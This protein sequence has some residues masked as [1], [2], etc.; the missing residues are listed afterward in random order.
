MLLNRVVQG[1]QSGAVQPI[2]STYILLQGLC[3][4]SFSHKPLLCLSADSFY[5]VS[6]RLTQRN[7]IPLVGQV[8]G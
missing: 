5:A 8:V 2:S 7:R 4:S 6:A 3:V 1:E